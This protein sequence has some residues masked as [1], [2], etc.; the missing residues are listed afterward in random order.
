[1]I[2]RDPGRQ[3]EDAGA[4]WAKVA[5]VAC[6]VEAELDVLVAG[7]EDRVAARIQAT[8]G[9]LSAPLREALRRALSATMRDV[10]ARLRSQAELPQELPPDLIELARLWATEVPDF[11]DAWLVGGEVFWDRFQVV[12]ERTLR[13]TALCWD[14]VKAARIRLRGHAARLSE[15]FRRA[16][17]VR[18]RDGD[19]AK[20]FIER[21]QLL[22][23]AMRQRNHRSWR[24][25]HDG[26]VV[27]G[28]VVPELT[29]V[30]P[31]SLEGA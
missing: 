8:H 27:K 22:L 15:L 12:A 20:A 6:E 3:A 1:V 23:G 29:G 16:C 28:K 18:R 25:R 19:L 26:D 4:V 17:E 2:A 10:L 31:M 30:E 5:E 9:A 24:V 21:E 11:S 13:D 14:V 7:V